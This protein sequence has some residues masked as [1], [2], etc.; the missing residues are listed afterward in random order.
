MA[1]FYGEP[2]TTIDQEVGGIE[3]DPSHDP[4][5]S[6]QKVAFRQGNG[7]PAISGKSRLVTYYNLARY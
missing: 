6:P 7:T 5:P 1:T 2:E 3:V 4:F